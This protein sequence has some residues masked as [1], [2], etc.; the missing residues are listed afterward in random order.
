MAL[1]SESKEIINECCM[2]RFVDQIDEG[3]FHASLCG[4]LYSSHD[5]DTKLTLAPHLTNAS[6]IMNIMLQ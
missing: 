3:I 6:L 1:D 5:L 2:I 4:L